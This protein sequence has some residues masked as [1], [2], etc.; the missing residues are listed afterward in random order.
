[1]KITLKQ[2]EILI[3]AGFTP[4]INT[5]SGKEKITDVYRKTGIGYHIKFDDLSELKAAEYHQIKFNNE[6]ICVKD[7]SVG[8]CIDG[9]TIITK[10]YIDVQDWIDFT[11]D[12]YHESYYHDG[13]THHNSGKSLVLY[14]LIRFLLDHNYNKILLLVPNVSLCNQLFSDFE[15]YSSHNNWDTSEFVHTIFSGK[16]KFTDHPVVLSTWQ[17]MSALLKNKSLSRESKQFFHNFNAV[18]NDEVH[19]AQSK[20]ISNILNN[21]IYADTRIGVTGTLNGTKIHSLQL[22]SLFGPIKKVISTKELM[23]NKQVTELSIKCVV[24]KHPDHICKEIKG[25][26]YQEELQYIIANPDRNKFIKNLVLSLNGNSLLLYQMVEKHGEI[27]YKMI[28]ESKYAK[29]KKVYFIHG[30]IK[31]EEREKIRHAMET[32]HN[33]IL[34]GSV[35]TVSTGTNIRNLHNIIFASPS[36]SRIRNLQAVGRVLRLS[37][38][39]HKAI[40]YDIADDLR[41]KK[42]TNYTLLHFYERLKIYDDEK[43]DY[44]IIKVDIKKD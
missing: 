24:L 15:D 38:N 2:L 10:K 20:E 4:K 32:E 3:K 27:L 14:G 9:K 12:A 28:S 29:D 34:I 35:G 25:F 39:K 33:V 37:E 1:M 30:N 7:L 23:D 16:E 11:I 13:I 17:S 18:I 21:C 40:L 43:F 26:K 6:W 8:D 36:K 41:Y 42:H 31:A 5:P 22:E 19:T 44:K